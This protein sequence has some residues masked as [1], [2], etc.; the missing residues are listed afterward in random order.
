MNCTMNAHQVV[1]IGTSAGGVEALRVLA[2]GLPA[3]FPLPICVVMHVAPDSPAIVPDILT[4]SGPLPS[5]SAANGARLLPGTIYVAP[6]DRHLLLEP[7]RLRLTR[8]PRENRFRPAIDPLFRSAAQV[9][10]P[11]AIAVI[12]TGNLDDGTAGLSAVK[13]LGGVGIVQNPNDA[14]FPSMPSSALRHVQ[15]DYV[16]PLA[17]IARVLVSLATAGM[18]GPP[19]GG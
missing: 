1:V 6:P 13:Q 14:L 12:L 4:R 9:Y 5:V 7:G 18:G 3:S 11:A 19:S 2:S 16:L 15:A 8:G 10:G 17:D